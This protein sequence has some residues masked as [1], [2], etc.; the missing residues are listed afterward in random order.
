V[1]GAG[2][3]G[4][5][6]AWRLAREG[7]DVSLIDPDLNRAI[8]RTGADQN[9]LSG[10]VASLGI[11]MGLV[12]RR[13]S[14]RAWRLRRR[15]MALWPAWTTELSSAAHPLHLQTS[16]VQLA[17]TADEAER[18]Q[19]LAKEREAFGLRFL[20]AEELQTD[21]PDWPGG[22]NGALE[23]LHDGRIDPLALLR[24]LRHRLGELG[25]RL[26][27]NNVES[28]QR[29]DN[30]PSGRWQ[31][32]LAN[33]D[34]VNADHVVVCSALASQGLLQGL[35]HN[36]PLA[37]VLGQVVELQLNEESPQGPCRPWP[38]VLVCQGINLVRHGRNRL[39]LGAT[40]EPGVEADPA[41]LDTMLD[42]QGHAPPWLKEAT[43]LQ[44]WQ[45]LRARPVERP[46]PLL[47]VLEP[48]LIVASGH[49]RN[50]VLLT[51]ATA[52]WVC[53]QVKRL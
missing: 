26:L 1:I 31:L 17:S 3:I 52:E 41:A 27:G 47:E 15:S 43:V 48:G 45:G 29:S 42:L 18:M 32:N 14:G 21:H 51:P 13:S 28:I 34:S 35:G 24:A 36:L 5:G 53:D 2:A 49:Y 39:W 30:E 38:A 44:R 23:S 8:E 10:T 4:A 19:R 46:A 9:H 16:L 50:G 25:V 22:T 7:H 33:S 37:P 11:L 40:L 12:F 6:C 20:S